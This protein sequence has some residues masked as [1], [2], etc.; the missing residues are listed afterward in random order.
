MS[1]PSRLI[2]IVL[3]EPAVEYVRSRLQYGHYLAGA[4]ASRLGQFQGAA[5][6]Y[7]PEGL[8]AAAVEDFR[9]GGKVTH[10]VSWT[11]PNGSVTVGV[12]NT[13]SA[14]ADLIESHL[15]ES[16][17]NAVVVE[18]ANAK[19]GDLYLARLKSRLAC[20]DDEVVHLLV[21]GDSRADIETT[22]RESKSI[23]TFIGVFSKSPSEAAVSRDLTQGQLDE[24]AASASLV[25]VGAYDGEGFVVLRRD[26]RDGET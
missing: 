21:P 17:G 10:G 9:S 12:G 5:S 4:V 23:P 25:F 1:E 16:A 13:Y 3:G 15:N 26:G 11:S 8:P 20:Y 19:R 22:I 14:L 24:I 2:E 6:T 7:L 18:N